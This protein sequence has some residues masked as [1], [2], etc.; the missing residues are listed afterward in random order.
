MPSGPVRIGVLGCSDVAERRVLPVL[1]R[2][3]RFQLVAV[4]S[5]SAAK[6][7]AFGERFGCAACTYDDLLAADVEAVYVSL[8]PALHHPWG[9]RAIGAGKHLLL[10]KPFAASFP[11]AEELV[12]LAAASGLV[13]MEGLMYVHHPL[14][15]WLRD[16]VGSG[17]LGPLRRIDA[18]FGFPHRARGDHRYDP[19]LGGGA[20]LD[21]LVYPLSFCLGLLGD[22]PVRWW[23]V[24]HDEPG[25]PVDVRGSM[26]LTTGSASASLGYGFGMS[27]RNEVRLWGEEGDVAVSRTFSRPP[28]LAEDVAVRTDG[29]T[30]VTTV[31]AADHFELML[32]SF[33]A[34][35]GGQDRSGVNEGEEVLRRMRILS[36]VRD[37]HRRRRR[38]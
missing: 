23:S 2:S 22:G 31:P 18:W 16:L 7:S 21:T 37:E 38:P 4:A 19:A 30:T 11:E 36:D 27:Y 35:I 10:D 26:L 9:R 1:E 8:P 24:V 33:A 20:T 5:R 14:H 28:E 13:A 25:C 29:R 34:K 3:P 17:Q 15:G 12:G 32:D 6:A